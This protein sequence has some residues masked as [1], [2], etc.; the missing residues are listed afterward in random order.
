MQISENEYD[1]L[2]QV[3]S[4][5]VLELFR[6]AIL[7]MGSGSFELG[8]CGENRGTFVVADLLFRPS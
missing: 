4:F 6:Q 1:I 7:P 3:P 5:L 2:L 8:I